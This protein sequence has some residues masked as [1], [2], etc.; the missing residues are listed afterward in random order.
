MHEIQ[1]NVTTA[2][3][4]LN[5]LNYR[6]QTL[7]ANLKN[8]KSLFTFAVHVLP[9]HGSIRNFES[10]GGHVQSRLTG[11]SWGHCSLPI[12]FS[13]WKIQIFIASLLKPTV[14][15]YGIV[16][17][18]G[19]KGKEIIIN[20]DGKVRGKVCMMENERE[21]KEKFNKCAIGRLHCPQYTVEFYTVHVPSKI[22]PIH[23]L[24]SSCIGYIR[25]V[26]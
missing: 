25:H 5:T 2:C 21:K 7:Y 14:V 23:F 19:N 24:L 12:C 16:Y 8:L 6:P 22:S 4:S 3:E 17:L 1:S 10:Y 26:L 20:Y 9:I 11:E 18:I 15:L 13:T